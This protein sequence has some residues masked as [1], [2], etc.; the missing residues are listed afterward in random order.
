MGS[1]IAGGWAP[2]CQTEDSEFAIRVHAVGYTSILLRRPYGWG[3]I[4]ETFDELKKQRFRWTYG[5][6][7]KFKTHWR[8]YSPGRFGQVS[9][10]NWQQRV[11]HGYYGLVVL[12]TGLAVL[13]LPISAG[14]FLSMLAHHNIP[15]LKTT[16]LLPL[17]AMLMARR[18]M[19]WLIFRTVIG[20]SFTGFLGATIALLAVKP[21]MSTAAFSVLIG[22]NTR[23]Q[24][25]NK[26]RPRPSKTRYLRAA[27]SET[28]LAFSC[29]V[30]S[31]AT[32]VLFPI[33][34]PAALMALGFGWQAYT[35]A[36]APLLAILA[37]RALKTSVLP[38]APPVNDTG[39][40]PVEASA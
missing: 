4:P 5:P 40:K 16:L 18:V 31:A 7:Q 35:F 20:T 2:W 38:A 34:V 10:L 1:I 29:L 17:G 23:W 22:K 19:R 9:Q 24:R 26:F 25:T 21:T 3:L 37:E 39:Y 12:V 28:V 15:A 30:A 36:T 6:G 27:W 13:S 14:L 8:L 33:S 32:L 11:R